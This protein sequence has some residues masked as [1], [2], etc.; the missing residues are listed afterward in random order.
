MLALCV[1]GKVLRSLRAVGDIQNTNMTI[2][3]IFYVAAFIVLV[4]LD[5]YRMRLRG[6]LDEEMH[7]QIRSLRNQVASLRNLIVE[8]QRIRGIEI[9]LIDRPEGT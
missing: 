3:E 7:M 2:L 4:I 1:A 5:L 8:D 9:T 6:V